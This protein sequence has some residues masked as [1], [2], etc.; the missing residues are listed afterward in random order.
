MPGV[1]ARTPGGLSYTQ[2]I[3]LIAGASRRGRI[4]GLDLVEFLPSADIDGLSALTASRI[5]V[6][7]IGA[8][9]RQG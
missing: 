2:T 9:V 4:V 6:N 8:I 1:A 7:A 3:D 5:L